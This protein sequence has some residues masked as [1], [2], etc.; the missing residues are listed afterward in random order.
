MPGFDEHRVCV[1]CRKPYTL[2]TD[3]D[4]ANP[5]IRDRCY[6]CIGKLQ[7]KHE[8]KADPKNNEWF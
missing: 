5:L 7:E 8:K 3:Y 2:P 4:K 1:D 6:V